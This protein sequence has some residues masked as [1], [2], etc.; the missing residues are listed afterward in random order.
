MPGYSV[1]LVRNL[2]LDVLTA[3][4]GDGGKLAGYDGTRPA[5]GGAATT[6]L[7]EFTMGTP[8]AAA[9]AAAALAPN[10]P[11]DTVG[12]ADGTV[13][14]A[15]LTKSD[16]TFVADYSIDTSAAEIIVNTTAITSG[17]AVSMTGFDI[18]AGDA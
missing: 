2:R 3:A 11:S 5:T 14:W 8:F 6:K 13:T 12:L 9:A 7:F 10:L 4:V 15:R 17:G 18:I 1:T 16:G